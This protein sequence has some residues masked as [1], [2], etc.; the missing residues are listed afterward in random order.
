MTDPASRPAE[1]EVPTG[2]R[3]LVL[4]ALALLL[5]AG[6]IGFEAWPLTAWR[7]FS[8]SRRDQQTM[9]VLHATTPSDPDRVIDLEELPLRY[10]HA[11]WP[12]AELP[13]A[14]QGRRDDVCRALLEPALDVVP[15]LSELRI[16]RDRQR[17]VE[18]DGDWVVEHAPEP[19][20][21][22]SPETS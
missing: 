6:L 3:R 12:M 11:A 22:C 14:S 2:G 4:A 17:L 16:V 8:L 15:E 9:W 21:A 20:H 19:L 5:T 7:L 10:R 1:E 18:R 13:G